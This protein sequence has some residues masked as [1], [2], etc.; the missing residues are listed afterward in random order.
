M[1]MLF[2]I[3]VIVVICMMY[4][5]AL[6]NPTKGL[7]KI[8]SAG[9]V[10]PTVVL[11]NVQ[12]TPVPQSNFMTSVRCR[13]V[14]DVTVPI[15]LLAANAQVVVSGW[16]WSNSGMVLIS[17]P[18]VGWLPAVHVGCPQNVISLERP[19]LVSPSSTPTVTPT[20]GRSS[21]AAI[22]RVITATPA[23]M[24]PTVVPTLTNAVYIDG[25]CVL[26]NVWGVRSIF[27]NGGT[28]VSGG[29][30]VCSVT[31]FVINR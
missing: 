23:P 6:S 14:S 31:S 16:S 28:P 25:D 7:E 18:N 15:G 12:P 22:I 9:G 17:D 13:M 10:T 20:L 3:I 24:L 30:R 19:Y 5:F 11:P 21:G 8:A 4:A 2:A 26:F 1:L 27:V 29:A